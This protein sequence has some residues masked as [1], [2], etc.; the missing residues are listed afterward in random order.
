[1]NLF[2]VM[3]LLFV[4]LAALEAL[5]TALVG[6][7]ILPWFNGMRWLRIHL[8]TLGTL[9]E[10]LFGVLPTLVAY[11]YNVPK[12]SFRW[13]I[14]LTLNA[15]LLTLLVGIPLVNAVPIYAGGTLVFIATLL[16]MR[17]LQS[18]RPER[19]QT[20]VSAAR[21]F[22]LMGLAFF[23]LG[24]LIGTGLWFGWAEWL[25]IAVPLEAH[26]HANNW[27]FMSLVFA[28]LIVDLY[29]RWT[30]R[31]L[32]WPRSV[33]AIFWLMSLGALGLVLGPWT[34]SLAFTVPG[35]ILH[36]GAT[37]WLLLNVVK[38]IWGDKDA[39]TPGIWHLVSAHVWIIAPVLVA[40]LI[41]LEVPGIPGGTVEQNAPQALI[42]GWLLQVGFA[43][44]P[45]FFR[46]FLLPDEPARLGGNW[47]SLVTVHIGGVFLWLGIF[48]APARGLLNGT[49]YAFWTVAML[50]VVWD[51]W[52][53]FRR[54]W[55]RVETSGAPAA[56]D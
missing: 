54:G 50:P 46:H 49:A 1:M 8:I 45:Y 33:N 3:A 4:V 30:G 56:S 41:I 24:I 47:I 39:W 52:Q 5:N 22:Y 9:T 15:G 44:I 11:R 18:L 26:I 51:L 43:I 53:T 20:A 55:A 37:L 23:L 19:G 7:G 6:V 31:Q 32:A 2:F 14:W 42:Y 16:L 35:L 29:P 25:R 12:P 10:V 27:G 38:P 34:T 48:I 21:K 13:E 28:G 36:L 40:P 17:Q